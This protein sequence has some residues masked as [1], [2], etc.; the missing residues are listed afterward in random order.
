MQAP[1]TLDDIENDVFCTVSHNVQLKLRWIGDKVS[2]E[3][4]CVPGAWRGKGLAGAALTR[5]CELADL[6]HWAL[7]L[8]PS[9]GFGSDRARLVAWY[10]RHGFVPLADGWMFR[11]AR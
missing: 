6:A 4:L 7:I 2:L 1:A 9:D 10:W 3:F 5:I 8:E 11:A